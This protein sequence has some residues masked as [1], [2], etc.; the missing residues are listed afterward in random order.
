MPPLEGRCRGTRR[1]GERYDTAMH[2]QP[3]TPQSP[4]GASS[5]TRGAFLCE[6]RMFVSCCRGGHWP[7]VCLPSRRGAEERG[8]GVKGSVTAHLSFYYRQGV[9]TFSPT[10]K[11]AKSRR[12]PPVWS[13]DS[14]DGLMGKRIGS[15]LTNISSASPLG[16]PTVDCTR[17]FDRQPI[18]QSSAQPT[19]QLSIVHCQFRD[20]NYHT[21]DIGHWFA[22]TVF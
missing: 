11:Y 6:R 4:V 21:G 20:G 18:F 5:P 9:H 3:F 10:R 7:S 2:F 17:Q 16:N 8:G 14:P 13:S 12:E 1:R 19:P 22:M 15:P